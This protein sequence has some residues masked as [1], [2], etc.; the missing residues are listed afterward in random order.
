M[1][2]EAGVNASLDNLGV[3]LREQPSGQEAAR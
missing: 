2:R 1:S 3:W